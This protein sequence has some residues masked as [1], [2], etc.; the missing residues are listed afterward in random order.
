MSSIPGDV[1]VSVRGLWSDGHFE[2]L[3]LPVKGQRC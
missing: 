3:V 2:T 1:M